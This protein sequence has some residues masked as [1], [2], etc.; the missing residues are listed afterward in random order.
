VLSVVLITNT[1][2]IIAGGHALENE[3]NISKGQEI[4]IRHIFSVREDFSRVY[5]LAM[6]HLELEE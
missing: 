6:V 3:V 2:C 1:C 5:H 4:L